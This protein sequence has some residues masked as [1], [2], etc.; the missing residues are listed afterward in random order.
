MCVCGGGVCVGVESVWWAKADES[1][2]H[3]T[4]NPHLSRIKY[5]VSSINYQLSNIKYQSSTVNY[6]LSTIDSGAVGNRRV[7]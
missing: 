4:P 2:V 1:L 6:Q 3:P 7:N 5:Q